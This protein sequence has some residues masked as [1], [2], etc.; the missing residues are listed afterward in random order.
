MITLPNNRSASKI[1]ATCEIYTAAFLLKNKL[2][3]YVH[4]HEANLSVKVTRLLDN[5]LINLDVIT[6]IQWQI[7]VRKYIQQTAIQL[8]ALFHAIRN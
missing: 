8:Y 4:H 3:Y 6:T 1:D 5:V 7:Y 2:I